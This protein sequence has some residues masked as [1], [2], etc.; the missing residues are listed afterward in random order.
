MRKLFLS[1]AI[2]VFSTANLLAQDQISNKMAISIEGSTTFDANIYGAGLKIDRK[3]TNNFTIGL[4]SSFSLSYYGGAYYEKDNGEFTLESDNGNRTTYSYKSSPLDISNSGGFMY[5]DNFAFESRDLQIGL[6]LKYSFY[7]QNATKPYLGLNI[8]YNNQLSIE[9]YD[10]YGTVETNES[11][12]VNRL[13]KNNGLLTSLELGIDQDI[14]NRFAFFVNI[15]ATLITS[16]VYN[17]VS[18]ELLD[19]KFYGEVT[20]PDGEGGITTIYGDN[21]IESATLEE[22]YTK[23]RFPTFFGSAGLS[24]KIF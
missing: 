2:V 19:E 12:I 16:L 18:V 1:M 17:N 20:V 6:R 21:I 9:P 10:E 5:A 15:R 14:N 23:E 13:P 8:A 22:S 3:I 4:F 7:T 11:I 24:Y